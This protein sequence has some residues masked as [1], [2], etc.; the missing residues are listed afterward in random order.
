MA[1]FR[2]V[3]ANRR[4][5]TRSTGPRSPEGKAVAALNGVRHGPL[6][7]A[8]LLPGEREADLVEFGKKV[9]ASLAPVGEMELLLADRIVTA[10]WR[11]RRLLYVETL[12]LGEAGGEAVKAFAHHGRD[13]MALLSRYEAGVERGLYKALHELQRMQAT[14]RGD[15]V[16]PPQVVDATIGGDGM[17]DVDEG[18]VIGFAPTHPGAEIRAPRTTDLEGEG[19][20]NTRLSAA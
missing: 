13:K 4:N 2:Q 3:E 7:A 1:S 20:G 5:A 11:L 6:S 10:G 17:E 16:P 8:T 19:Q 15:A 9:R 18:E 12:L 14:R